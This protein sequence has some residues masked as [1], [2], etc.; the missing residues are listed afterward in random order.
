MIKHKVKRAAALLLS[1]VTLGLNMTQVSLAGSDYYRSTLGTNKALGSPLSNSEFSSD[2]W[3]KWEM[4]IFG[5]FIGNYVKLGEQDYSEAFKAGSDGLKAMQFAAGGDVNSNGVLRKMINEAITGQKNEIALYTRYKFVNCGKVSRVDLETRP[6]KFNDLFPQIQRYGSDEVKIAKS[7]LVDHPLVWMTINKDRVMKYPAYQLGSGPDGVD[8]ANLTDYTGLTIAPA[9]LMPEFSVNLQ[10]GGSKTVFSFLDG[11]DLQVM[12]AVVAKMLDNIKASGIDKII[13]DNPD[14]VLDGFGNICAKQNGKLIVIIPGAANKNLNRDKEVN[15]LNSIV[16]NGLLAGSSDANMAAQGAAGYL[17]DSGAWFSNDLISVNGLVA[18]GSIEGKGASQ[19]QD[20][21]LIMY[22]DTDPLLYKELYQ[23]IRSAKNVDDELKALE[24]S[25]KFKLLNQTEETTET[26]ENNTTG[27]E[28]TQAGTGTAQTGTTGTEATQAGTTASADDIGGVLHR[29]MDRP[30]EAANTNITTGGNTNTTQTGTTPATNPSTG[31]VS[32]GLEG[33]EQTTD[34]SNDWETVTVPNDIGNDADTSS[35]AASLKYGSYIND[36]IDGKSLYRAPF[37]LEIINTDMTCIDFSWTGKMQE[38]PNPPSAIAMSQLCYAAVSDMFP[39]VLSDKSMT[40][41]L[42]VQGSSKSGTDKVDLLGEHYYLTPSLSAY[43]KGCTFNKF[44]EW[45]TN[46]SNHRFVKDYASYALRSLDG[47]VSGAMTGQTE[48]R[49]ILTGLTNPYEIFALLTSDSKSDYDSMHD[50]I[51]PES[52]SNT[53]AIG[54]LIKKYASERYNIK[55]NNEYNDMLTKDETLADLVKRLKEPGTQAQNLF[56]SQKPNPDNSSAA[57]AFRVCKVYKPSAVFTA[58]SK[59]FDLDNTALFKQYTTNMYISYLDWYGILDNKKESDLRLDTDIFQGNKYLDIDADSLIDSMSDEEKQKTIMNNTFKMLDTSET[60]RQYRKTIF[61]DLMEDLI[62][63]FYSAVAQEDGVGFLNV[64][65]YKDLPF[66]SFIFA[67]WDTIQY[68]AIAFLFVMI[69]IVGLL[70]RQT[71]TWMIIVIVVSFMSVV[72]IPG[73]TEITPYLCNQAIQKAFAKNSFYWLACEQVN[74]AGQYD[75][76]NQGSV[77]DNDITSAMSDLDVRRTTVLLNSIRAQQDDKTILIKQDISKKVIDQLS[78]GWDKLQSKASTRWLVPNLIQQMSGEGD[79]YD[80]V[81]VTAYD[82]FNN[83]TRAYMAAL[84]VP[85]ADENGD[86]TKDARIAAIDGLDSCFGS[87][88]LQRK[89]ES[90]T[91]DRS[92]WSSE[93]KK[94]FFNMYEK[95]HDEGL[96]ADKSYRSITRLSEDTEDDVHTYLYLMRIQS[97]G[98]RDLTKLGNEAPGMQKADWDKLADSPATGVSQ[99]FATQFAD[100]NTNLLKYLNNYN[101]YDEVNGML[102]YK[103][104]NLWCTESVGP[105]F[106]SLVHDTALQLGATDVQGLANQLLGGTIA[107]VDAEGNTTKTKLR[108]SFMHQGETG[109]VRDFLD[110]EELF[111]NM[112]PYMYAEQ[113]IA[114]GNGES[115]TKYTGLIPNTEMGE[116]YD[117]YSKN[118]NSWMYRSNWVTK[119]ITDKK[120]SGSGTIR[121]K[122]GDGKATETVASMIDPRCYVNRPMVFSE[123]Q[124]KALGL[125]MKDLNLL[126]I[127]CVELNKQVCEDWTQLINFANLDGMNSEIMMRLM[128]AKAVLDFDEKMTTTNILGSTMSLYPRGLDLRNIT[129]DA[130]LRHMLVGATHNTNYVS[131]TQLMRNII[132]GAGLLTGFI[133]C[134]I[135][136]LNTSVIPFFRDIILIFL[137]LFTMISALMN[138]FSTAKDKIKVGSA[139]FMTYALFGIV[140]SIFYYGIAVTVGSGNMNEVLSI[141]SISVIKTTSILYKVLIILALDIAYAWLVYKFIKNVIFKNGIRGVLDYVKTGGFATFYNIASQATGYVNGALNKINGAVTR[142]GNSLAP[143]GRF[144]ANITSKDSYLGKVEVTNAKENGKTVPIKTDT[145]SKMRTS[146]YVEGFGEDNV[147][148]TSY[149]LDDIEKRSAKTSKANADN[150]EKTIARG[151]EQASVAEEQKAEEKKK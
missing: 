57:V 136:G 66:I 140:T 76:L 99:T 123:A 79:T 83:M 29:N 82:W 63:K 89:M 149:V 121:Y 128:T 51:A 102:D 98:I 134:I 30:G 17:Q 67:H 10:S 97:L 144:T 139:W 50:K 91:E 34:P 26:T 117:V 71:L 143:I 5:M 27:T 124:M 4:A 68:C 151:K 127:K 106:Y 118:E 12:Q 23:K 69:I 45:L 96:S 21:K 8:S 37:K 88:E 60:G 113:L 145:S 1:V 58:V 65:S 64:E 59:I 114:G 13:K 39:Y 42:L 108:T 84:S 15:L 131:T 11:Y 148:D 110:L 93:G 147:S 135:T 54:S 130:L 95:T 86:Y 61:G 52:F 36:V 146:S 16:V 33:V 104:S 109:Y 103:L 142:A 41:M 120:F 9:A 7:S 126:E 43:T 105:Y 28:N 6:A 119:L 56:G 92:S 75:A 19:L 40:T 112:I 132:N 62:D 122:S 35:L 125:E 22:N 18:V 32:A 133:V 38:N 70:N 48:M 137:F 2:D 77:D 3:D 138:C 150:I 78:V 107:E 53:V 47:S 49:S 31:G 115:G 25:G 116:N 85:Q 46:S 72:A 74:T 14:L 73:Y 90:S 101:R 111:T 24:E 129:W 44:T 55:D 80:Y 20:G 94:S 141:G 100:Y 81:Y 87:G